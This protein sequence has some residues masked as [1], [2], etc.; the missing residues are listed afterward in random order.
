MGPSEQCLIIINFCFRFF[1][2]LSTCLA[3]VCRS[4]NFEM[5]MWQ[6]QEANLHSGA[7]ALSCP[8]RCQKLDKTFF[9]H[10]LFWD[11]GTVFANAIRLLTSCVLLQCSEILYLEN[12]SDKKFRELKVAQNS[13]QHF[14]RRR[15][16][17][18]IITTLFLLML[19]S[20]YQK[21]SNH[22]WTRWYYFCDTAGIIATLWPA[23]TP[24][25]SA[26]SA[27]ISKTARWIF[28]LL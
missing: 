24:L 11:A 9:R 20:W 3:R 17:W 10:L 12:K 26:L 18:V 22:W 28:F 13:F 4:Y 27:Y 15:F 6:V 14:P 8:S 7:R 21:L 23:K 19:Q 16:W 2:I 25:I 5:R 1:L